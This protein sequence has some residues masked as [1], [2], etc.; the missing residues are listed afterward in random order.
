LTRQHPI[1]NQEWK[2][3]AFQ[4]Q[5]R[6]FRA[7]NAYHLVAT[8]LD[9][10]MEIISALLVI[11]DKQNPHVQSFSDPFVPLFQ[12]YTNRRP[13]PIGSLLGAR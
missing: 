6:L 10:P 8:A 3:P 4:R 11:L 13:N 12:L 1:K 2:I 9:Q 5:L 7:P